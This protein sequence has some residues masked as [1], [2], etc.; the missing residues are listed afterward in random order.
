MLLK[1]TAAMYQILVDIFNSISWR[2][3][4][5]GFADGCLDSQ[6]T[7]RL[8]HTQGG[9]LSWAQGG[10]G[11]RGDP[12]LVFLVPPSRRADDEL[13]PS[14]AAGPTFCA[15][16]ATW[17]SLPQTLC[18]EPCCTCTLFYNKSCTFSSHYIGYISSSQDCDDLF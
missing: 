16:M 4:G 6:A 17:K 10:R 7:H 18:N 14:S 5:P 13:P 15:S 8:V 3:G 11:G 9:S 1:T 2:N 12:G